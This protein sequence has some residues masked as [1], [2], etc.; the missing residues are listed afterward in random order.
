MFS[1]VILN[2]KYL[3]SSWGLGWGKKFCSAMRGPA[4]GASRPLRRASVPGKRRRRALHTD[5]RSQR[6]DMSGFTRGIESSVWCVLPLGGHQQGDWTLNAV[7]P[8]SVAIDERRP[9]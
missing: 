3:P 4:S 2:V 8:V 9:D 5:A 6:F 1:H 7:L